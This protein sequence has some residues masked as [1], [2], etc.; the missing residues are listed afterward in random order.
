MVDSG[1]KGP[2]PRRSGN[3]RRAV[4]SD[5]R[6]AELLDEFLARAKA[7][8][9]PDKESFIAAHPEVADALRVALV[10][11]DLVRRA[12]TEMAAAS[13]RGPADIRDTLG[14]FRVLR[15]V[16]RGGMG[17]RRSRGGRIH[18]RGAVRHLRGA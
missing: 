4:T 7:G 2:D 18:G 10:G 6:V 8:T 3:S 13:A 16:G 17:G 11:F 12:G 14:D 1:R 5:V 9:A 15:E